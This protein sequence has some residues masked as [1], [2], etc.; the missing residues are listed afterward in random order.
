MENDIEFAH[1]LLV[2]AGY[3]VTKNPSSEDTTH[4]KKI[5]LKYL[6]FQESSIP[7]PDFKTL[8]IKQCGGY[9]MFI[10]NGHIGG[11]ENYGN[12]TNPLLQAGDTMEFGGYQTK[13]KYSHGL[14]VYGE[15]QPFS[16]KLSFQP[17]GS[18]TIYKAK[19]L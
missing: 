4:D 14:V 11:K 6:P 9:T 15:P 16:M 10:E 2:G 12:E 19:E 17:C 7:A 5:N 3:K 13:L 8:R 18:R 1:G